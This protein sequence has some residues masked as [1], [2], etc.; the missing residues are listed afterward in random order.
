MSDQLSDAGRE[1]PGGTEPDPSGAPP[2]AHR[3]RRALWLLLVPAVLYCAAPLV[4]DSIEPRV[5]GV[6]F[7]LAWVIMA[8]LVSPVVIWIVARLD[9]AYRADALEP[10]PADDV[11]PPPE[12]PHGPDEPYGRGDAGGAA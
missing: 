8:T 2:A 7:L 3:G 6:P 9:P 5:L 10:I 1:M 12:S 11:P 4:A